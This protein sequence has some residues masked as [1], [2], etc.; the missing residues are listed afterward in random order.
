MAAGLSAAMCC[1]DPHNM[2][3][4]ECTFLREQDTLQVPTS[5]L[6]HNTAAQHQERLQLQQ[7]LTRLLQRVAARCMLEHIAGMPA[8]FALW[9]RSNAKSCGWRT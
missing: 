1:G 3:L 8:A 7:A 5:T 4:L 9:Q 6:Q 2:P